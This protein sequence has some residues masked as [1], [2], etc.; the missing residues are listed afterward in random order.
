MLH[1]PIGMFVMYL[2]L[3][4]LKKGFDAPDFEKL[5]DFVLLLTGFF[6]FITAISGS[7]LSHEPDAYNVLNWLSTEIQGF[8]FALGVYLLSI[9]NG[10]YPAFSKFYLVSIPYFLL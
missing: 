1:L 6:A 9:I 3:F 8:G 10:K 7:L 5:L 4:F 2:V